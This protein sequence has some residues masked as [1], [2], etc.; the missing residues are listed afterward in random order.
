[1]TELSDLMT[2]VKDADRMLYTLDPMRL[3]QPR[4]KYP[5]TAPAG[6]VLFRLAFLCGKLAYRMGKNLSNTKYRDKILNGMKSIVALPQK[7]FQAA[8]PRI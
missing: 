7:L 8:C 5:C 4:G 2:E 1:M 3:A 6:F